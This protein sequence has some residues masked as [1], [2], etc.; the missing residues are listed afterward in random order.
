ME[1]TSDE[2]MIGNYLRFK[3]KHGN[4]DICV[5]YFD[6]DFVYVIPNDGDSKLGKFA[7]KEM[8]G[9]Q[10]SEDIL[11]NMLFDKN[12]IHKGGEEYIQWVDPNT[13]FCFEIKET[14]KELGYYQINNGNYIYFNHVHT[15]QNLYFALIGQKISI[16]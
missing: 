8:S 4:I 16:W 5:Y 15:L 7:I 6:N 9:V 3:T 11:Y 1:I 10:I 13:L 14:Q 2:L 12:I